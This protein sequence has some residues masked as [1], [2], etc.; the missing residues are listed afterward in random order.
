MG[1]RPAKAGWL[2]GTRAW[3]AG[4]PG[5]LR[6]VPG[7]ICGAPGTLLLFPT[8]FRDALLTLGRAA[9]G[10]VLS[11]RRRWIEPSRVGE[12]GTVAQNGKSSWG[13]RRAVL[14]AAW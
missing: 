7:W 6:S 2:G 13:A 11:L 10:V 4:A 5:T 1:L 9:D 3:I 8:L 12:R 14:T